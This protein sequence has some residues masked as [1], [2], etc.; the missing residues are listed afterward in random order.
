MEAKGPV[1]AAGRATGRAFLLAEVSGKVNVPSK[2]VS[3]VH[4]PKGWFRSEGVCET[5][6]PL[7]L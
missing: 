7:Q 3:C 4:S 1:I 2:P 5:L 6:A